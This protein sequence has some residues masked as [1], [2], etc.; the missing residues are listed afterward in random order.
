MD[1]DTILTDNKKYAD[2][3]KKKGFDIILLPK[4]KT[5][6]E[7][8]V[9]SLFINGTVFVPIFDEESDKKAIEVYESLG[10][11]VVPI[12]TKT[13]SNNGKGSIH[14]ITMTYPKSLKDLN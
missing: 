4:L 14:C 6:Y 5:L 2:L 9:N 1:E 11:N 8:Y 7:T 12:N 13:L 10:W 3:L